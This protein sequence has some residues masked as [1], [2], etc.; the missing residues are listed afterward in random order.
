MKFHWKYQRKPQNQTLDLFSHIEPLGWQ[1]RVPGDMAPKRE[2]EKEALE[3]AAPGSLECI[4]GIIYISYPVW[5]GFIIVVWVVEGIIFLPL[6]RGF[7]KYP[8]NMESPLT[9]QDSMD[10]FFPQLKWKQVDLIITSADRFDMDA[11][12]KIFKSAG[13]Y[14]HQICTHE[15]TVAML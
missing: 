7:M 8:I 5:L 3:A 15:E 14:F 1:P 9:N 13:V 6:V 2:P 12:L 10:F 11:Q 4:Y